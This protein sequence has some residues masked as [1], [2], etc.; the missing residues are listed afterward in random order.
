[1]T[2]LGVPVTSAWIGMPILGAIAGSFSGALQ[3]RWA[4][5]ATIWRGR[6]SCD[7][8][9]RQLAARDLVPLCSW[10]LL[11]GRCRTCGA[12]I[13]PV[14]PLAE[15]GCALLGLASAVALDGATM[16][17]SAIFGWLLLTLAMLDAR[18]FWLPDRLTAPLAFGGLA[19]SLVGI[20]PPLLDAVT[21]AVT[22][23]LAL[24][25][26]AEIYRRWRGWVGL[27]GGDAKLVGA[28]GLWLGPSGLPEVL[29]T[30]AL[31]GLVVALVARA[32]GRQVD[33][34]TRLPFGTLLA[35]AAWP[36]WVWQMCG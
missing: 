1:M 10:L 25:V 11:R 27:G 12:R 31:A 36:I 3:T 13:D 35:L 16:W 2:V 22:G 28:L 18:H 32:A 19:L 21:A 14:Q 8:C 23:F 7:G 29:L 15:L 5:G 30:A 34:Q 9:G 6:S 24:T 33:S 20:G 4:R 26:L 17:W